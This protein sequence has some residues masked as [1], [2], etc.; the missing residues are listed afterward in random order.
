MTLQFTYVKFCSHKT[1][2]CS[3]WMALESYYTKVCWK[4]L[5]IELYAILL[6]RATVL[7]DGR[8]RLKCYG[9]C[10]ET[11]FRLSAQRTSPFKSAG[12]VSSVNYW[13]ASCAHQPAGFVLLVPAC[14]LQSCDAYWLPPHS[15]VSP[16]RLLA[17]VVCHHISTGLCYHQASW[18]ENWS[19]SCVT[20]SFS[21]RNPGNTFIYYNFYLFQIYPF[22]WWVRLRKMDRKA[23]VRKQPWLDFSYCPSMWL[24]ELRDIIKNVTKNALPPWRDMKPWLLE[25]NFGALP[26]LPRNC[27]GLRTRKV[28]KYFWTTFIRRYFAFQAVFLPATACHGAPYHRI[29]HIM[30][31]LKHQSFTLHLWWP[32]IFPVL[33]VIKSPIVLIIT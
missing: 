1:E 14:V 10:A 21:R 2:E 13:Q 11:R 9:T 24:E 33:M 26:D 19:T 30:Y 31:S 6:Q 17:C 20:S 32:P 27:D 25:C 12:G 7:V 16:S 28:I 29:D 22:E 4:S 23:I 5:R 8:L 3:D 18:H 15:L